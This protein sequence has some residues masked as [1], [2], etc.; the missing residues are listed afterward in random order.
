VGCSPFQDQCGIGSAAGN[1]ASTGEKAST[2][3]TAHVLG[4]QVGVRERV[5]ELRVGQ[6]ARVVG[7]GQRH[8]GRLA[9]RELEQRRAHG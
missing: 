9:A 2:S 8:E 3:S 6:A 1:T 4:G 7:R 5:V